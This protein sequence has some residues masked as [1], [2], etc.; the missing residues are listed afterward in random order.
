MAKSQKTKKPAADT[1]ST[2]P[3]RPPGRTNDAVLQTTAAIS[4]CPKCG[5]TERVPYY[6]RRERAIAGVTPEGHPYT[7]VVWRRT[8][9]EN[10]GQVRDDRTY[11]QRP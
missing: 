8:R 3:G 11:E 2:K 10:C 4:R 9:C 5:S 1:A 6:N 7:H